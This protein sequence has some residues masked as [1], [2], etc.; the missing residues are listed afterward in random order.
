M[1]G[2]ME[3]IQRIKSKMVSL[4]IVQYPVSLSKKIILPGFDGIPLFNVAL[5]FF[6]GLSRGYLS[7]RAA[8]IAFSVFLAIFPF[9]IFLFSIIPFIPIENFQDSL[10]GIIRDFM[11]RTAYEA[12]QITIIDIVTRPR[13][14]VLFFNL[15]L[16]LYFSTNGVNSLLEAFSN[17]Y[18]RMESRGFFRQY[19]I[20][21]A[22][23]LTNSLWLII[24]IGLI[25]FG[26][27]LLLWLLPAT[28]V[29]STMLV[30]L[31]QLLRW[32]IILALLVFAI[33][34]L[35]YFGTSEKHARFRFISPG[36]LMATGLIV[37]ST[38]AFTF[39]VDNFSSY[40]ALY[41]SLG[42]LMIV[43]MWIYMNAFSLLIGFELNASIH[44]AGK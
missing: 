4:T 1:A 39:Y 38:L 30:F 3:R 31:I 28:I 40:N 32:L 24:S 29:Q 18:H 8:A 21:V 34:F 43:L 36:A 16:T 25:T 41:G 13:S 7:T 15:L 11:P 26:S 42:T 27:D 12:V 14:G 10:L 22:I 2:V 17:T 19:M 5:F 37:V 33:S 44:T 6:Q 20:S 35:Y 9:F 23:V